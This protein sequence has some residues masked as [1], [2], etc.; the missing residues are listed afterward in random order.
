MLDP[1][2]TWSRKFSPD[3]PGGPLWDVV[4]G[5]DCAEIQNHLKTLGAFDLDYTRSN[6]ETIIR[7]PL[8]TEE[9]ARTSKIFQR[10]ISIQTIEDAFKDFGQ[11]IQEGGLLFL[12]HIRK[13][14][15]R[16]NNEVVLSA[17]ILDDDLNC[18][19]MRK[20]IPTDFKQRY[21][22]NMSPPTRDLSKT[23]VMGIEFTTKDNPI[24]R[25][26]QYVIQHTMMMTSGNEGLDIWAR[27]RKLYPWVALAAP[28]KDDSAGVPF[29]GRLFSTLRLPVRTNQPIHIH[30]LFSITPDRGRLSSS[31]QSPGY[32]DLATKWNTFMFG[33]CVATAW[34]SLLAY[35]SPL[36]C[37]EEMFALWPR[38]E[39][40]HSELW[41]KLDDSVIDIVIND[42][43]VVWNASNR[44]C[45][46]VDHGIF[47]SEDDAEAK[48]FGPALTAASLPVVYL[49]GSLLK[50]LKQRMELLQRNVR[51]LTPVTA[52]R[53]FRQHGLPALPSEINTIILEFCLLDAIKSP[54]EYSKRDNLYND[55]QGIQIWP[56]VSGKLSCPDNADLILPRDY[57]EMH[58]FSKSRATTTLD[59][60]I[61]TPPVK[62]LLLDDIR[63]LTA[64]MRFRGLEDLATDWP[65]MY[66]MIPQ[67]E[68]PR[69]GAKRAIEYDHLLHEIWTWI[70]ERFHEGQGISP[71]S[72]CELWL[73]PMDDLRIRK[74][75]PKILQIPLLIIQ[76]QDPLYAL[77]TAIIKRNPLEMPRLLDIDILP[78]KAIDI[79]RNKEPMKMDTRCTCIDDPETFIEW[80]VAGKESLAKASVKEK[81]VLLGHLETLTRDS[82]F[83]TGLTPVL[84][85]RMR[86]LPLYSKISCSS[87]FE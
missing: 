52:R 66:P 31:G 12:K 50:K 26:S 51:F 35:R 44:R 17:Q 74:L 28:L 70:A 84:M 23:F 19:S 1:H 40:A 22:P 53:F 8:R 43:M 73:V 78:E 34:S 9:Q 4:E 11:E 87:P 56:T 68:S 10:K 20:S 29:D 37:R 6:N 36:S 16:L 27:E 59:L 81:A 46:D 62:K 38:A 82:R 25:L 77:L 13:I 57:A 48:K 7:I 45:V 47:A 76:K 85:S 39:F 42:D 64:V 49:E 54:L 69:G 58:L 41:D 71:G 14:V 63:N 55:L 3:D 24:T 83:P 21:T 75:D 61:M 33:K 67:P 2:K 65:I 5:R 79:L 18:A 32:E 80:L 15:I 30:G 60:S 72:S 86:K